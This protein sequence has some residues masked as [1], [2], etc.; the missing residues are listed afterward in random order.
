MRHVIVDINMN[1]RSLIAT[2]TSVHPLGNAKLLFSARGATRNLLPM[3]NALIKT[4]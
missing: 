2:K 1:H 3:G 4:Y